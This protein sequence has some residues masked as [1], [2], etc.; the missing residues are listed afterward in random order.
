M[1][2]TS[3]RLAPSRRHRA[4]SAGCRRGGAIAGRGGAGERPRGC[5]R[6]W[7]WPRTQTGRGRRRSGGASRRTSARSGKGALLLCPRTV[8]SLRRCAISNSRAARAAC[9]R[10]RGRST[11]SSSRC[12]LPP[13]PRCRRTSSTSRLKGRRRCNRA[14]VLPDH[15]DDVDH[16]HRGLHLPLREAL[17]LREHPRMRTPHGSLRAA[18]PPVR[19]RKMISGETR[20]IAT[21]RGTE[22]P[23]GFQ[24]IE[25]ERK[26][27][28]R[29]EARARRLCA[30]TSPLYPP[31]QHHLRTAVTD[32]SDTASVAWL[33]HSSAAPWLGS[34]LGSSKPSSP[35]DSL[36]TH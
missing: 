34:R 4:M 5:W 9:T 26:R 12:A 22:A 14:G 36:H 7:P 23:P 18:N 20:A 11:T 25:H 35:I 19:R 28:E 17:Q 27:R 10:S 6:R 1:R 33:R 21:T 8:S 15:G 31:L 30:R 32:A 13:S 16:H 3:R 24:G 29:A 2:H